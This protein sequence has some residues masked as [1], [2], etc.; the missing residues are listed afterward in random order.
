MPKKNGSPTLRERLIEQ[1]CRIVA[2]RV[3]LHG[4][5]SRVA[6]LIDK[7]TFGLLSGFIVI[8][9]KEPYF[10]KTYRMIRTQEKKQ[11]TWTKG[12]EA[13]FLRLTNPGKLV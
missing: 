8:S 10:A 3:I 4:G 1:R 12:D 11:G 13:E 5:H 2:A 9:A 6:K 7:Q